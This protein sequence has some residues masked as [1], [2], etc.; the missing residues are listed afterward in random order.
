[1]RSDSHSSKN[2]RV[3]HLDITISHAHADPLGSISVAGIS[4]V[5]SMPF[6]LHKVPTITPLVPIGIVESGSILVVLQGND[7][8]SRDVTGEQGH[9]MQHELVDPTT[10]LLTVLG[11]EPRGC[12]LFFTL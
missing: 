9:L 1:M 12:M 5:R 3:N 7:V 11:L 4:I 2:V 10:V 6:P 8:V